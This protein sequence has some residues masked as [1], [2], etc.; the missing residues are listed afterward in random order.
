MTVTLPR[1]E[2]IILDI[3]GTTSSTWFVQSI[4]YPYSK[5]R[6]RRYLTEFAEDADITRARGQIIDQAGLGA[7]ATGEELATAL[8]GWLAADEKRTPLKTLQG[9]IWADGFACGDLTSHFFDDAI[10]AIR[11]WHAEGIRLWIFS[12]G[13]VAAQTSWFG[14]TP[15]GD[16]LP[17]FSGHF[18]TENAGPKKVA[19]S[20][21]AIRATIGVPADRLL[22]LSDLVKELDAARTDG[23][24]TVGVRREGDEYFDQGVGGHAEIR[25]FDE[26]KWEN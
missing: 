16:L 18:D 13:S 4:L 15:D 3:E 7:D 25:S 1:P 10:P 5:E 9:R 11:R 6:F 12:S 17:L 26:I 19:A 23:W 14:N 22:F 2:S 20:Y 24:G 8:E 21:A